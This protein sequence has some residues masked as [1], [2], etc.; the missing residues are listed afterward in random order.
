VRLFALA[1]LR[2]SYIDVRG[3]GFGVSE[4]KPGNLIDSFGRDEHESIKS[5]VPILMSLVP[6]SPYGE[7]AFIR[8]IDGETSVTPIMPCSSETHRLLGHSSAAD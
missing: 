5:S 6:L 7:N 4:E 1:T 3:I 8:K 2:L